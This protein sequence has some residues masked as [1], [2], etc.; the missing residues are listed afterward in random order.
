[1]LDDWMGGY[2]DWYRIAKTYARRRLDNSE[3]NDDGLVPITLA[4]Q[5]RAQDALTRVDHLSD[6]G[7]YPTTWW[8]LKARCYIHGW[9]SRTVETTELIARN[10]RIKCW[11][12]DS[13]PFVTA[14]I[15]ESGPSD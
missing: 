9:Q 15:K 12:C 7:I 1:M 10:R 2:P 8:S 11:M 3:P 6:M 4:E 13:E 5:Y 14:R